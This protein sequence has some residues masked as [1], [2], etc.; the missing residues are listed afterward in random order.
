MASVRPDHIQGLPAN[1]SDMS[2]MPVCLVTSPLLQCNKG[3][4]H[5]PLELRALVAR[6][7][8]RRDGAPDSRPRVHPQTSFQSSPPSSSSS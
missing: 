5:S 7:D 3:W 8:L 2:D 4:A 6:R 1:C